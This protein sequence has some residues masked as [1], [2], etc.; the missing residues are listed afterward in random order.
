MQYAVESKLVRFTNSVAGIFYLRHMSLTSTLEFNRC[1]N[2]VI[3]PTSSSRCKHL[4]LA[5]SLASL[6]MLFMKCLHFHACIVLSSFQEFSYPYDVLEVLQTSY[7]HYAP[8][9][10]SYAV[11]DIFPH[12]YLTTNLRQPLTGFPVKL[13]SYN[14]MC[15]HCS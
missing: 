2:S 8:S 13:I 7:T 11:C 6:L 5:M 10:V 4:T 15:F 12:T 9:F 1:P 14:T 3:L